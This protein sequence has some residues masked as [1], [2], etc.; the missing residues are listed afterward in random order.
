MD[1]HICITPHK[2]YTTISI[3]ISKHI[4]T[5]GYETL[6]K[7]SNRNIKNT[8]SNH[9][10]IDRFQSHSLDTPEKV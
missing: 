5:E 8:K 6:N 2:K 4:T 10:Y 1:S 9:T 3:V 7:N